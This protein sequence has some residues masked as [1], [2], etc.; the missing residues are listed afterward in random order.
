MDARGVYNKLFGVVLNKAGFSRIDDYRNSAGINGEYLV[1]PSA[2]N[3]SWG[4]N[5]E[6]K[7]RHFSP[8]S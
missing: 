6:F 2:F 4:R 5:D 7:T 8:K 1:A 3:R